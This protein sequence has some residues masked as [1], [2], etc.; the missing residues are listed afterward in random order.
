MNKIIDYIQLYSMGREI[1]LWGNNVDIQKYLINA[2]YNVNKIFT[3]NRELLNN[4]NFYH[5]SKLENESSKY[6][7]VV[8]FFL[9]DSGVKQRKILEDFGYKEKKDFIFYPCNEVKISGNNKYYGDSEGN[10][11]LG[12]TEKV[13]IILRGGENYIDIRKGV[14]VN[15]YLKIICN[16]HNNKIVIS[17]NC[18]FEDSNVIEIQAD[19]SN[20]NIEE[21]CNFN[22]VY[23]K[24]FEYSCLTIGEKSSFRQNNL[25][26][27]YAYSN[28]QIGKDCMFSFNTTIQAGD[29][30]SIFDIN[31]KE[32]INMNLKTRYNGFLNNLILDNHIWVGRNAFL[33]GSGKK[34]TKIGQ[35]S[36][37]GAQSLVKGKF[38]NNLIIGGN[39]AKVIRK[40]IAWSRKPF[41]NNI[42]DCNGFTQFTD[43]D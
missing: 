5:T 26:Y 9:E 28:V 13:D 34:Q 6:Y 2:G 10:I 7:I 25:I 11:I 4:N 1:V 3:G 32:N 17:A 30:H 22:N 31:L 12:Q 18:V 8:P 41:S 23:I 24:T 20:I 21:S 40:N 29:G 43:D 39:P 33:L 27:M 35:G 36:I 38:S 16:G 15:G 42:N 14:K 19:C 37:I